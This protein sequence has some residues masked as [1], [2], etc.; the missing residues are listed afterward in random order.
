MTD[1]LAPGL[2]GLEATLVPSSAGPDELDAVV[3]TLERSPK[4]RSATWT[5]GTTA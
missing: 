2:V 5:V 3:T 4:V 1:D